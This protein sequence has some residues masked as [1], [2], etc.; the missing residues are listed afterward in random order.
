MNVKKVIHE[1]LGKDLEE[2]G[3][4][5]VQEGRGVWQYRREKN[6][7]RQEIV[8][9][10]D[11]Y[12]KRYLKVIL[13]TNAYGQT[14]REFCDFV[15]E[16]GA[17][18]WEF[19]SYENEEELKE[20][21][22]KF[23]R[24]IYAYGLEVLEEISKPSTDAIPTEELHR[25][26]YEN[27]QRLYEE[28]REKLHT[29]DKTPEEVIE[30]I[31]GKMDEILDIPFDE[32]KEF[33]CGLAALYGHTICWGDKGNW[34]WIKKEKKCWLRNILDTIEEVDPLMYCIS[35]W[36]YM[37]KHEEKRSDKLNKMYREILI[38]YYRDHPEE[39]NRK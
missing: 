27:H 11:R 28:Y 35:E 39:K 22:Q 38:F 6:N 26:L 30:I 14:D 17:E 37:R 7:V 25:N 21:I 32:A 10:S 5:Y 18:K 2:I 8:I 20:I 34:L 36:D 23:K 33:L 29:K 16:D 9:I 24:L 4:V 13:H 1:E 3:F 19:W 12:E 15:P 31:Y